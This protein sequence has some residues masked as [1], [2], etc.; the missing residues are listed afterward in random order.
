MP[1]GLNALLHTLGQNVVFRTEQE[2]RDFHAGVD[3]LDTSASAAPGAAPDGDP[4]L[5]DPTADVKP[6]PKTVAAKAGVKS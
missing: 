3:A 5:S 2:F 1:D 4:E 6:S